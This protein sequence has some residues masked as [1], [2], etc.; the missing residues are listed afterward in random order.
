VLT[1][2]ERLVESA[3]RQLRRMAMEHGARMQ[4]MK[5]LI[6]GEYRGDPPRSSQ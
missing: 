5:A 6:T 2:I 3:P 1:L 4:K